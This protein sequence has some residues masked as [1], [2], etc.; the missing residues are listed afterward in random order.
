MALDD[1]LGNRIGN[2]G[3]RQLFG[4]RRVAVQFT[5]KHREPAAA[6]NAGPW[7]PRWGDVAASLSDAN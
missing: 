5:V 4:T 1:S 6:C 3:I 2:G 7:L